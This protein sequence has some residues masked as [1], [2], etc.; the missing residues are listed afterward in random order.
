MKKVFITL[1]TMLTVIPLTSCK[2]SSGELNY[3]RFR[4]LTD[5]EQYIESPSDN[6]LYYIDKDKYI[7]ITDM[8][9]D[10]EMNPELIVVTG[11]NKYYYSYNISNYVEE[12]EMLSFFNVDIAY[13]RN[14]S[15]KT[16]KEIYYNNNTNIVYDSLEKGYKAEPSNSQM[17]MSTT[18]ILELGERQIGY[19][20]YDQHIQWLIYKYGAY[21]ITVDGLYRIKPEFMD[22]K[23]LIPVTILLD[24]EKATK[25]LEKIDHTIEKIDN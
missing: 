6:S 2:N 10:L 18:V 24:P 16:L 9:P 3:P 25:A 22:D 12:T 8:F 7:S 19:R 14:N 23:E 1:L 20:I 13:D 11:N 15:N 5:F 21:T 4:T 17:R